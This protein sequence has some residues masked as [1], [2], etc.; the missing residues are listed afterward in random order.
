MLA[1]QRKLKSSK[2]IG[3]GLT[4]MKKIV[5]ICDGNIWPGSE[6]GH[7]TTFFFTLA[8]ELSKLELQNVN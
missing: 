1:I 3:I 6:P 7:G 2:T 5:E 8:A 4:I